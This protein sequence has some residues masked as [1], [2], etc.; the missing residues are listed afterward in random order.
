MI[1][2]ATIHWKTDK[3]INIQQFY[4]RKNIARPYRIFAFLNYLENDFPKEFFYSCNENIDNHGIK[5]NI[6]ADVIRA[7]SDDENDIIIFLDGDAFPITRLDNFLMEQLKEYKLI[8]IQRKENFGD[9]HPHPSFCATT[10]KN[11]TE[12]KGDWKE[13]FSW[14]SQL[15]EVT[16]IGG[17]LLQILNEKEINWLPLIR[18]NRV[19]I[20]PLWFGIYG[21]LIYHHGAGFREVI[22]RIDRI[23]PG[24]KFIENAVISRINDLLPFGLR[25]RFHKLIN[26]RRKIIEKNTPLSESVYKY[27]KNNP[28]FYKKLTLGQYN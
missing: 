27:V 24:E 20:H 8:A 18:S 15:G 14:R 25:H 4:L 13:G 23:Q 17:N 11:W 28:N 7:S 5:L 26:I 9:L 19:N 22:S 3:W 6:L 1:N 16:D 21:D 10:I 2:I 12:M